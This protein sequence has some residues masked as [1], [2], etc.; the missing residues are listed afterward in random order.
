MGEIQPEMARSLAEAFN[1]SIKSLPEILENLPDFL[2]KIDE[3]VT[4]EATERVEQRLEEEK[5]RLK[6]SKLETTEQPKKEILNDEI[7]GDD[8]VV[9]E[10]QAIPENVGVDISKV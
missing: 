4:K 6:E 9:K 8:G 10:G 7:S 3:E 5:K 1:Q 2:K